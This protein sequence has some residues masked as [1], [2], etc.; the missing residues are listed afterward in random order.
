MSTSTLS[1]PQVSRVP[2]GQKIAFG[3]GM[4]GNQMFPAA[5]GVFMVVLVQSLKMDVLLAGLLAFA[6]RIFDAITDP[7]MGYISDNTKSRWGR[8]RPYILIGAIIAGISFALMWQLDA[9]NSEMYN[10]WYFLLLSL[11]FYLGLTIF[12]TPYVAMGYEM[13]D[14]YH[15]RTRIMA[16]AQWIGQ[17]AWV[18]GPWFWIIIYYE[19]FASDGT[20]GARKLAVWVGIAC[21]LL[22]AT[23][24][25]FCRTQPVD[26]STQ[27]ELSF[28]GMFD[29]VGSLLRG[30]LT[31]LQNGPFIRICAATFLIFGSFNTVAAFAFY[32]IVHHM[33]GGD[34]GA[35]GRWPA[36]HGSIT[37]LVTTFLA[38]PVVTWLS[39]RFGKRV[40]F[41]IS[42]S[43][44]LLGYVA[45]WWCFDPSNPWL[46]FLPLP[47]FCF[48]IGGL[49]TIMM[50][51]TADI[52][53]LDELNTGT[54]SE[55]LFGAVYWWMTKFGFAL[56][57]LLTG[58]IFSFVG[59]DPALPEQTTEAITGLRLAYILVPCTGTLIAIV[60][61]L[62]YDLDEQR[63]HEIREQIQQRKAQQ[64]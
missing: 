25:I 13:S 53:D 56:A 51:M 20:E 46:L 6:P 55:G 28:R 22:A 4:L 63:A 23:P 44:S 11:V 9:N 45:Y 24:A 39:I 61:M 8:R 42:Q 37:A 47:L 17:W 62:G 49:F 1:S 15:E 2:L 27:D 43:V 7:I 59:Y 64:R 19:G 60:V 57:G 21:I 35:A 50:S 32:I 18:I 12:A 40:A 29:S 14:D 54:R 5:L 30:M 48:G 58:V 26:P 52:C 38:I 10:F 41:L 31:T 3:I 16:I 33:F 36:L 34:P